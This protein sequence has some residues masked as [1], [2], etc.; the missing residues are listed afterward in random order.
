MYI[1]VLSQNSQV[2]SFWN[3]FF[4]V[5]LASILLLFYEVVMHPT[6]VNLLV[7]LGANS[8]SFSI[9][10]IRQYAE[11]CLYRFLSRKCSNVDKLNWNAPTSP[12]L[13]IYKWKIVLS[14]NVI[15]FIF[16]RASP[17]LSDNAN[18]PVIDASHKGLLFLPSK[19]PG[20]LLSAVALKVIHLAEGIQII[21]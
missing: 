13:Q 18:K 20:C 11:L 16:Q 9:S 10:S 5:N 17:H 8:S 12:R 19:Q 2:A 1:L 4:C 6:K 21:I 15:L 14:R 7:L 3:I